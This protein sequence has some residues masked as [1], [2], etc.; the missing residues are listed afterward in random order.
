M[1]RRSGARHRL[2]A[3]VKLLRV[4]DANANR[5]RE[6]LRVSED[7]LRLAYDEP[8]LF[9]RLRALRHGVTRLLRQLPVGQ[10]ELIDARD[11]R[12]D[13]GRRAG[14]AGVASLHHL[15]LLN[16][17]RAKEA[18]RVLEE[19]S[20]VL[21][22]R[23]RTAAGFQRLRFDLYDAERDILLRLAALRHPRPRS[24]RQP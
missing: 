8:A 1:S 24:R 5:A 20:R 4:I 14:F 6:G 12:T 22:P 11:T 10:A 18:L 13:S 9:R 2:P 15:L 23:R 7:L 21:D 17:Q 16:L 3:R 19:T